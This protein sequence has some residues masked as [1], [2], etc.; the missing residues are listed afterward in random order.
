MPLDLELPIKYVSVGEQLSP[1][2]RTLGEGRSGVGT[3]HA[4]Q[5]SIALQPG[6]LLA[7]G[8]GPGPARGR[9]R[10]QPLAPFIWSA[11]KLN[12]VSFAAAEGTIREGCSGAALPIMAFPA[13]IEGGA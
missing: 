4:R 2:R 1:R 7:T 12:G 10:P 6:I 3:P 13:I 5:R 11:R 9:C 8:M